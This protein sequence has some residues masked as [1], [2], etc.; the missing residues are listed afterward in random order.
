MKT[1]EDI[2]QVAQIRI[3]LHDTGNLAGLSSEARQ[4]Q[5]SRVCYHVLASFTRCGRPCRAT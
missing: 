2:F 1:I 4:V 3:I 5:A